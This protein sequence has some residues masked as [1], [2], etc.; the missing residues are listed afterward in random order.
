VETV[1]GL[2]CRHLAVKVKVSVFKC[3][4][5]A[6]HPRLKLHAETGFSAWEFEKTEYPISNKEFQMFTAPLFRSKPEKIFFACI[7]A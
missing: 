7:N 4:V 2:S 6:A 1:S 5:S 3:R